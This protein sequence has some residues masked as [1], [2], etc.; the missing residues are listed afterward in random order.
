MGYELRVKYFNSFWLKKVVGETDSPLP[1]E[2]NTTI[3]HD[4]GISGNET[5]LPTWPGLPWNPDGYP[6]FPWGNSDVNGTGTSS[7]VGR[8]IQW[9]VEEA[10]IKG[11][12]NNTTVDF[13]VRAYLTEE[14]DQQQNRFSTLIYS[15]IFNSRTG[16]N[17][18]NVFSIGEDITKSVDPINGSI[19]KLYAEDTNL[20]IFQE[21]KVS[22][23]LIDK[24]AI[25]T[26]EG[27]PIQNVSNVVIGQVVPYL[28]EYGISTNPESFAIYG[29]GKYFVD[30][31]RSAVLRLSRDGITEI[32]EYGMRDYFRDYLST[33]TDDWIISELPATFT[34]AT[35][36]E[37][38]FT[39]SLSLTTGCDCCL[40][41]P[42][43]SLF[44]YGITSF[45]G[46]SYTYDWFDSGVYILETEQDE[47]ICNIT[48]SNV[49]D[50][51]F[52]FDG[53]TNWNTLLLEE[54]GV[55]LRVYKK[56]KIVGGWDI[57][58]KKYELSMQPMQYSPDCLYTQQYKTLGFD[59]SING[60]VSFYSYKPTNVGSLKNNYYSFDDY[61]LYRHYDETT[62]NN[63]TLFYGE[64]TGS[65]ITFIFNTNPSLVK[66]FQTVNY[67]GSNG[68]Q[69]DSIITDSTGFDQNPHP[70]V[71]SSIPPTTTGSWG[72]FQDAINPILS[73][74]A[75][76]YVDPSDDLEYRAGFDRRENKYVAN[77]VNPTGTDGRF[78]EIV[79]GDQMSGVKGY[80]VTTVFSTDDITDVGGPK[81]LWAVASKFVASSL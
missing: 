78:G 66:N 18:T 35:I 34:L 6:E 59:E 64:T 41:E 40:L 76:Y 14:N 31:Y 56:P 58:N 42:G 36:P 65:N 61:K 8:E 39:D 4:Y 52:F 27:Q 33:V 17:D 54:G 60:W 23:A 2:C 12:F 71:P 16:I 80:Y 1:C 69:V 19:Q 44:I 75:G 29:Y 38:Q 25:Y 63:R 3:S 70:D 10:R 68:W 45:D 46:V 37:D 77:L 43:M 74:E 81:E 51:S 13:G 55:K 30:K 22:R 26:A 24:D 72:E 49:I 62:S 50:S 47:E 11:G 57:H 21:N 15:G 32:S 5:P 53:A 7:D 9:F 28:G 20:I 73:Y 67:E 48:L 79:W